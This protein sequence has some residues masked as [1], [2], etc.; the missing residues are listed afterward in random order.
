MTAAQVVELSPA[1]MQERR[2]EL[3]DLLADAIEGGASMNYVLPFRREDLD[4]YWKGVA[5]D[6]E[7]RARVVLAII[8]G[9]CVKGSVQLVPC[10]KPNQPHR[11][12][13]E[14]LLVLSTYRQR[15]AGTALMS[16]VEHRARE[17]G[18]WLLTLDTRTDSTADALY[19][20]WGWHAVGNIPDYALD[21]DGKPAPCTIYWK[22]LA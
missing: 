10:R 7:H 17:S 15:G 4:A 18:R 9:G 22:R 1:A 14:K 12:D 5:V 6:V 11:A 13:V 19:P 3:V 21:P 2:S 20:R 8:D 16:A